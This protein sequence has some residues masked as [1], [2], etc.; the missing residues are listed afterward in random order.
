[1]S[2]IYRYR[3]RYKLESNFCHRKTVV[4]GIQSQFFC[5]CIIRTTK[6]F[7]YEKNGT[8]QRKIT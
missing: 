7:H 4:C 1:M 6:I 3:Y 2:R 5:T 8:F